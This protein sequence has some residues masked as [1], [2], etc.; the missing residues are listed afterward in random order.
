MSPFRPRLLKKLK[1]SNGKLSKDRK[2]HLNVTAI[3]NTHTPIAKIKSVRFYA[4]GLAIRLQ[5]L[6]IRFSI[7]KGGINKV[8]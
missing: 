1:V 4:E 5:D 3:F 2:T 8:I 6:F 7:F